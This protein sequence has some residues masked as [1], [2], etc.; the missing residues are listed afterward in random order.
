[1]TITVTSSTA[2]TSGSDKSTLSLSDLTV[3]TMVSVQA[4]GDAT[5]GYTATAITTMV[6]PA[7]PAE[8]ETTTTDT[9]S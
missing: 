8:T 6:A 1:M 3:G 5:S 4:D 7:Q 9:A 2:I